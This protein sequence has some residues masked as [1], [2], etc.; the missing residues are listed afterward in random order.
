[1]RSSNKWKRW[2]RT[3]QLKGKII[4]I[5]QCPCPYLVST[6]WNHWKSRGDSL[7][8]RA[9]YLSSLSARDYVFSLHDPSTTHSACARYFFFFFL[10]NWIYCTEKT[11]T[12]SR[13][14]IALVC[15]SR[16][17]INPCSCF[18]FGLI[19]YNLVSRNNRTF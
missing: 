7:K 19:V 1:M 16:R 2:N 6:L 10:F 13:H 17:I 3:T 11:Q 15:N 8:T 4:G 5:L 14:P 12:Q 9:Q 18:I